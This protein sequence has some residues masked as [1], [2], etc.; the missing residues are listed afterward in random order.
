VEGHARAAVDGFQRGREQRL[1]GEARRRLA[2]E[3]LGLVAPGQSP[4]RLV[5]DDHLVDLRALAPPVTVHALAPAH[6][7]AIQDLAA[8]GE[9]EPLPQPAGLVEQRPDRLRVG[10]DRALG[11]DVDHGPYYLST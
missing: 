7:G 1:R 6:A 11:D 4:R 5:L 2:V 8:I 9:R 3:T 10:R